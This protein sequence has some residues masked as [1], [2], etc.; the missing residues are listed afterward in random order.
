MLASNART[1]TV[2]DR[3]SGFV[4][5]CTDKNILRLQFPRQLSLSI[6]GKSQF[7]KGLGKQDNPK[8]RQWAE[9]IARL[10]Q[11]DLDHP[12]ASQLF[13]PSLEKYL[14]SKLGISKITTHP[15]NRVTLGSIWE[16]FAEYKFRSGAIAETTY[17]TKYKRTYLN[18]LTPYLD[19]LLTQELAEKI[20]FDLLSSGIN[21]VNLKKLLAALK[22]ACDRAIGKG[23][24]NRNF[25]VGLANN[26][27]V[28]RRSKQLTDEEDYRNFTKQE[29]DIIIQAFRDS[30]KAGEQNIADMIEF[31]FLTGCRLGEAFAL[32][33]NDIKSDWI[34]FDQ[35]YSSE[36][37]ITKSTKTDTI[38]I[39]RT[40]GYTRLLT[41]LDRLKE[42][43]SDKLTDLVFTSTTGKQYNR[44]KLSAYWLGLH[45]IKGDS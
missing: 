28:E 39:F 6:Y 14:G 22:E 23:T 7:Y 27:K 43:S 3:K 9:S 17:K 20:A 26:I 31:L 1:A 40:K 37:K 5:V 44:F 36:T 10:I 29:R 19:E 2:S 13:D 30:D 25:F 18:W 35:S 33:W 15:A 4:K 38:R 32:K 34:V 11:A 12:D 41:L 8:N 24:I 45:R 16:D 42:G 21:R